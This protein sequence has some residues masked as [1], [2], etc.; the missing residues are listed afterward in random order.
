MKVSKIIFFSAIVLLIFYTTFLKSQNLT[1]DR[2]N[3]N[4]VMLE[5]FADASWGNSYES[6]R[7]KFLS[8]ATN[9]DSTEKI[10]LMNETKDRMLLVRRNGILYYYRFY[11]TPDL[12]KDARGKR[13]GSRESDPTIDGATEFRQNGILFSVGVVFNLVPTPDIR[14]K[15]ESKYGKPKKETTGDDKLSGAVLWEFVDSRD[16][17]PRG[18][19]IVQW[20]EAYKKNA[21]S[22]RIDYYS[23]TIKDMIGK[24]YK[25]YFSAQETKTLRDII[26]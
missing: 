22:R 8:L 11:K 6:L 19:Y 25:E 13:G 9:P 21:Y 2:D 23:A 3:E 7:E 24:E 1:K 14:T 16:A 5:G 4:I 20:K 18:G 17:I 10:E 12:V 15:L 26:D